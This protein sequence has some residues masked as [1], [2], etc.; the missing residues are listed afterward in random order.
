MVSMSGEEKSDP[1]QPEQG[2]L[3]SEFDTLSKEL[4][5]LK[6]RFESETKG[7][8]AWAKKWG[9]WVALGVAALAFLKSGVDTYY[10][11]RNKPDTRLFP[12]EI[13]VLS[14]EPASHLLEFTFEF[15]AINTGT[16]DDKLHPT[17]KLVNRTD[18]QLGGL[19]FSGAELECSSLGVKLSGPLF[20]R[21]NAPISFRCLLSS[22]LPSLTLEPFQKPG[23]YQLWL[24]LT[25]VDGQD[26][27]L[28]ACFDLPESAMTDIFKSDKRQEKRFINPKCI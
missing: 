17:G 6:A 7:P 28:E 10:W 27:R 23:N 24:N 9:I 16:K 21:T 15:S 25:G 1:P 8:H 11:I 18:S 14:Y 3:R 22:N 20:V 5:E 19:P 4:N 26:H 12:I 13:L 2:V